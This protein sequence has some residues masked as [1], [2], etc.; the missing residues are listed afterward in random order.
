MI[1]VVVRSPSI[2]SMPVVV[3]E[4]GIQ[5]AGGMFEAHEEEEG[6]GGGGGGSDG[7]LRRAGVVTEG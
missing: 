7:R 5:C 3:N 6:G 4:S 2:C 1:V